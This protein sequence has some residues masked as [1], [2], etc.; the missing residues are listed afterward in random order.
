[1]IR[2]IGTSH[3]TVEPCTVFPPN[4]RHGYH[5]VGSHYAKKSTRYPGPSFLIRDL[6]LLPLPHE[7]P[8]FLNGRRSQGISSDR[9]SI[10][11]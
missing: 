10:T 4:L 9:T 7:K 1:M 3:S 11:R 2:L 6:S 5:D 8:T